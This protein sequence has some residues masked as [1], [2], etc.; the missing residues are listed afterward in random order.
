M[1]FKKVLFCIILFL[2]ACGTF[3]I[4]RY[5]SVRE[6]VSAYFPE[7]IH[8]DLAGYPCRGKENAPVTIIELSDFECR[9][10]KSIQLT[11]DTLHKN[12]DGVIKQYFKP[13]PIYSDEFHQ[14]R[15][16]AVLAA[17]RQGRY[18]EMKKEL[19]AIEPDKKDRGK[20]KLMMDKIIEKARV[21]NLDIEKFK[22]D[23]N[24]GEVKK[25]LRL[26]IKETDGFGITTVPTLFINGTIVTGKRGF[27]AY[28]DII[29]KKLTP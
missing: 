3:F 1:K 23:I 12:L 20:K 28:L 9:Y 8:L 4:T 5:I 18:W 21:L 16:R 15:S 24:S 7:E 11:L 27:D 13:R 25:E 22:K 6:H 17:N 29:E 14:L 19:F 2:M 26:I 10:S